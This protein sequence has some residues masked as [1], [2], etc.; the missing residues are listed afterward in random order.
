MLLPY[1]ATFVLSGTLSGSCTT[2][3]KN[4]C[5][6]P[7]E[8]GATCGLSGSGWALITRAIKCGDTNF[9]IVQVGA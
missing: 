9:M 3:C 2:T 1:Q 6:K 7:L 4:V 8:R 5:P